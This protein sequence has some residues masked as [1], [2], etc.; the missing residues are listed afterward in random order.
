MS[1]GKRH[2]STSRLVCLL[3]AAFAEE[4]EIAAT[5]AGSVSLR[6]TKQFREDLRSGG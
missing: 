4:R 1:G 2:E 5:P 6:L 3:V